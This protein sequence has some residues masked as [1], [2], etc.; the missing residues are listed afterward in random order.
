MPLTPLPNLAPGL[1]MNLGAYA[2]PGSGAGYT[3]QAS[4]GT[5]TWASPQGPR[6][7]T[8][9]GFGTVAGGGGNGVSRVTYGVLSVGSLSLALLIWILSLIHISEPTRP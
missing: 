8:Q 3:Q 5:A 6:T 7:A 9:A 2:G 4:K 1:G